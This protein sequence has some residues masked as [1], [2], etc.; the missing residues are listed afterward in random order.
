MGSGSV[1]LD[2]D[3]EKTLAMLTSMTR[4]T[5]LKLLKHGVLGYRSKALEETARKPYEIFRQLDLGSGGYA[6][7]PAKIAKTTVGDIIRKKPGR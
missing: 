2:E 7:V 6:R 5:I 1:R 3:T 4:L